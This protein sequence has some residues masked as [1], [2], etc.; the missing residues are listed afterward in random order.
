MTNEMENKNEEKKAKRL[1]VGS[2][3]SGLKTLREG[4]AVAD[5]Q[6][7]DGAENLYNLVGQIYDFYRQVIADKD[8]IKRFNEQFKKLKLG[9]KEDAG[10]ERKVLRI[11]TNG[12][13][14]MTENR[15]KTYARVLKAAYEVKIHEDIGN[16]EDKKAY[17]SF[18]DWVKEM[19][20]FEGIKR[21]TEPKGA[22]NAAEALEQAKQFYADPDRT[23]AVKS[24]NAK[25]IP[26]VSINDT[27]KQS[28]FKVVLVRVADNSIV[29]S[30]AA[31]SVV[32]NAIKHLAK[33][34]QAEVNKWMEKQSITTNN[35]T[36]RVANG[37]QVS[38]EEAQAELEAA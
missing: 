12:I 19:G 33:K 31:S 20:G 2:I 15:Y 35:T 1:E 32:N 27:E 37:E 8:S 30:T 11:A 36:I 38:A 13:K 18:A 16:L 29:D 7:L 26:E 34:R 24:S 6:Y 9:G 5:K 21:L 28:A 23:G 17:H 14:H 25:S 22:N 4:F 10:I 3:I